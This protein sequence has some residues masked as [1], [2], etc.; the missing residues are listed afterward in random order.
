[1]MP[2]KI[3]ER[4]DI[5]DGWRV[6]IVKSDNPGI[7]PGVGWQLFSRQGRAGRHGEKS[8]AGPFGCKASPLRQFVSWRIDRER[9]RATL[10][11]DSTVGPKLELRELFALFQLVTNDVSDAR[12]GYPQG[13]SHTTTG[14]ITRSWAAGDLIVEN[15][16]MG[17]TIRQ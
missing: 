15:G 6:H 14:L 2:G 10:M 5:A 9:N 3:Y 4:L 7:C 1:M 12:R 16:R 17:I 11:S 13:P 8:E